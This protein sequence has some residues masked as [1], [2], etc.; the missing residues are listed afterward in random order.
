MGVSNLKHIKP[1]N[2]AK[3]V[4]NFGDVQEYL[5]ET[6]KDVIDK[7]ELKHVVSFIQFICCLVEEAYSKKSKVN[8][9]EEVFNHISKFLKITLN[10]Q[11][12]KIIGE[13]IEDLHSSNRIKKVSYLTKTAYCLIN[14][15]LKKV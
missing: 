15:F 1:S 2:K 14:M 10:D 4:K 7:T 6:Y 12:K 11:D 9:K 5:L 13:I 3:A 8:K